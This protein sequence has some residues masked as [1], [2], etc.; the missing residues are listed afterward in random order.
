EA[1]LL[2]ADS[3]R[4]LMV[5]GS[6]DV[7]EPDGDCHAIGSGG[8]YALAAARALVVNSSLS[9]REIAE[10]SLHIAADICTFTNHQIT[11]EELA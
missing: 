5:S 9:A 2:V 3:D 6:G 10:K 7:L 4:I 11:V 8:G 1:L